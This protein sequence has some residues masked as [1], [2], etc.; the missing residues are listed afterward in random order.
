M[1]TGAQRVILLVGPEGGLQLEALEIA[2]TTGGGPGDLTLVRR[3]LGADGR[4]CAPSPERR[5]HIFLGD[6]YT[7]APPVAEVTCP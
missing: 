4:P 6:R 3:R 2:A 1:P 5:L 7:H